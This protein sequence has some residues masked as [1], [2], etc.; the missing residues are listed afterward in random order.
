MEVIKAQSS[1]VLWEEFNPFGPNDKDRVLG[2]TNS[3]TYILDP[4]P[5][6]LAKMS[7]EVTYG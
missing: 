1:L 5:F 7:W 2:A 3:G 4:C 6:Q